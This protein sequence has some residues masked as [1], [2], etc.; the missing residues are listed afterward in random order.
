[1]VLSNLL[2]YKA[3]KTE[4]LYGHIAGSDSTQPSPTSQK[5]VIPHS[6]IILY[7]VLSLP[8]RLNGWHIPQ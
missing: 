6:G 5:Q 3:G 4:I 8:I 7:M 2:I 1:M